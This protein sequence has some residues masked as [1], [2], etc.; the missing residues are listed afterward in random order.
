MNPASWKKRQG[1]MRITIGIWC[2]TQQLVGDLGVSV[3]VCGDVSYR[4]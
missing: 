1:Y 4:I 3:T 2:C